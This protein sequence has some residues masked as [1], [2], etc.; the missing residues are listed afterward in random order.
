M[1]TR[2]E[3]NTTTD[4]IVEAFLRGRSWAAKQVA[5]EYNE[6]EMLNLLNLDRTAVE[7]MD[8]S[9]RDAKLLI[10]SLQ[11]SDINYDPIVSSFFKGKLVP[12]YDG[13]IG[14][15]TMGLLQLPRCPLPDVAPP[16][17][18]A[19]DTGD[20]WLNKAI[21]SM[22]LQEE[23]FA[24][25]IVSQG[26][27]S[28]NVGCDPERQ[29]AHSMRIRINT[30]GAPAAV[31]A[32]LKDALDACAL[33]SAELGL[34]KRYIIDDN[35]A[36]AELTKTF[37]RLGGGTIGI[38]YF[39]TP[40]TCNRITG[41]FSNSYAPSWKLWA[42]LE[43]H[44]TGHGCGFNH[45]RGH[46][47][48]PSIVLVWPLSWI[49]SPTEAQFRRVFGGKKI[50]PTRLFNQPVPPDNPDNPPPAPHKL[51]EIQYEGETYVFGKKGSTNVPPIVV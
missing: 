18:A 29:D 31:V 49:G 4:V 32:Y 34:A 39:N 42:N 48:N 43:E 10:R 12:D 23:A 21:E 26:S 47:M 9:E 7:K 6:P 37:V 1:S 51:I 11:L 36:V 30:S 16:K 41:V 3:F 50:A 35:N 28:W 25:A 22:Q 15:A 24:E 20:E 14:P 19:F 44:E 45:T 5:D 27:G 2:D 46:I 13:D 17:G 33:C 40:N 8:G 38:N